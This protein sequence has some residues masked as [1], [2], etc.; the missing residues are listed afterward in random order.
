MLSDG[1][2]YNDTV[3]KKE[4]RGNIVLLVCGGASANVSSIKVVVRF[5]GAGANFAG[6]N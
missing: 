2:N 4:V 1:A 5:V 3:L 6:K